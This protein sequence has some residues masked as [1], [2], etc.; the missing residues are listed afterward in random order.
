MA[1]SFPVKKI[2]SADP[3]VWGVNRGAARVWTPRATTSVDTPGAA[4]ILESGWV[5]GF[6]AQISRLRYRDSYT[7]AMQNRKVMSS[8]HI[9]AEE[10]TPR[11]ANDAA[12][13]A[14]NAL[15]SVT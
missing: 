4:K 8:G 15:D 14:S 1:A 2:S 7:G 13:R 5:H 12:S 6:S 11:F 9:L 10:G 3:C